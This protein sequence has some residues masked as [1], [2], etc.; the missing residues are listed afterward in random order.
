MHPA[1]DVKISKKI[2]ENWETTI[3]FLL[4]Y[5]LYTYRIL[6][7]RGNELGI[8]DNDDADDDDGERGTSISVYIVE[9]A[10]AIR[11]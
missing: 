8:D 5:S 2:E 3:L 11:E 10:R 4:V 1:L 7:Y 9:R 6:T